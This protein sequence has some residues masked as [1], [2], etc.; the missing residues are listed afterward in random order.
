MIQTTLIKEKS[1][2]EKIKAGRKKR[3]ACL[4]YRT[5]TAVKEYDHPV[6]ELSGFYDP[7]LVT[8][9]SCGSYASWDPGK[10]IKECRIKKAESISH[11]RW[12]RKHEEIRRHCTACGAAFLSMS[13]SKRRCTDRCRYGLRNYFDHEGIII[14]TII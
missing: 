6:C 9:S 4:Y 14:E 1:Y 8:C 7:S 5:D 12:P 13:I 11:F 10:D 3:N 2:A